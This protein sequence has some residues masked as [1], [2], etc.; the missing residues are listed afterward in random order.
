MPREDPAGADTAQAC[1]TPEDVA[2]LKQW[3]AISA[4]IRT[5][6]DQ[7]LD[8]VDRQTGLAPSSFQV[9]WFLLNSPE[10]RA[11]MSHLS[12]TL[13]FST[14]GTTKVADRLVSAGLMERHP[15]ATDRRVIF[16]VLTPSGRD[17]ARRAA[18]ALASA[19]RQRVVTPLGEDKLTHLAELVNTL[20][21]TPT[22]DHA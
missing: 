1:P 10:R 18:L 5:L 16:A 17:V 12:Q 11:P 19:L 13:G 7:L 20:N 15:S 6:T 9:L 2:V 21:L 3:N 22:P 8:D 4:G 14:A